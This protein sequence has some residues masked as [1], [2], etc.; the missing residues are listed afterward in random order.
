MRLTERTSRAL[1]GWVLPL[2]VGTLCAVTAT[3]LVEE[4]PFLNAME[5]QDTRTSSLTPITVAPNLKLIGIGEATIKRATGNTQEALP[6]SY[7]AR[8]LNGLEAAGAK[9]AVIDVVFDQ[10][11]TQDGGVGDRQLKD[12]LRGLSRLRVTLATGYDEKHADETVETNFGLMG[13][14]YPNAIYVPDAMPNVRLASADALKADATGVALGGF[15]TYRD[16][17]NRVSLR[18]L[19]FEAAMQL[20]RVSGESAVHNVE[21]HRLSAPPLEWSLQENQAM[22]VRWPK[23][24]DQISQIEFTDAL[25]NLE[26]G[27]PLGE[28]ADAV[29]V[30][31]YRDGRDPCESDEFGTID[32]P[33][34]VA[35][36]VNTAIRT[37]SERLAMVPDGI[38]YPVQ[39]LLA[40]IAFGLVLAHPLVGLLSAVTLMAVA[41]FMPTFFASSLGF[42][43]ARVAPTLSVGWAAA[44]GFVFRAT[45]LFRTDHRAAGATEEATAMFVDVRGSTRLLDEHGP[46]RYRAVV[47]DLLRGCTKV[48]HD[49]GATIERTQG[50]GLLALFRPNRSGR[51]ALRATDSIGPLLACT[52]DVSARHGVPVEI[53]IGLETGPVTGEYVTEARGRVWSS[54]GKTL[55]LAQ[56]LQS[57]SSDLGVAAVLGPVIAR[58]V[59]GERRIRQLGHIMAK[60]FEEP[61]EA[62][63]LEE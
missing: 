7:Y 51:H 12:S 15:A 32:G 62:F 18:H 49:Q 52:E 17:G 27:D 22:R 50:D 48:L 21:D 45:P 35:N 54:T 63:A 19:A 6:R 40:A 38:G 13:R 37:S 58:L 60:G 55:N 5:V 30:I 4:Q 56:R 47:G 29:V 39:I 2:V 20:A 24:L 3:R 57:A 36:M 31:G 42:D 34:F 14:F 1:F 43:L 9:V 26:H 28:F 33:M 25:A 8:L 16:L 61:I 53:G 46:E 23:R 10:A 59:E 41:W 44:L 11:V